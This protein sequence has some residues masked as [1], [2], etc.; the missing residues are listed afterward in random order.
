MFYTYILHSS[1]SNK[2][3][4]G[5]CQNIP[6]RL[7]RHNAGAT[8]STKNGRPWCVVYSE[9]FNTKNEALAR[10]KHIKSMKSKIYIQKLI[11]NAATNKE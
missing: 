7:Q 4:I 9:A 1:K 2:F 6:S 3:Y 8:P 11:N 10:E 5:A